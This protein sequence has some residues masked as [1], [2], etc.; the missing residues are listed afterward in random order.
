MLFLIVCCH[1]HHLHCCCMGHKLMIY[2]IPLLT[3]PLAPY[4][5]V[6]NG[7]QVNDLLH[8]TPFLTHLCHVHSLSGTLFKANIINVF[9]NQSS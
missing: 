2:S 7:S 5:L 9:R 1:L 3:L 6:L 8:S 4:A